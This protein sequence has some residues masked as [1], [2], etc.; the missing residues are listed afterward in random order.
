MTSDARS[1]VLAVTGVPPSGRR[2]GARAGRAGARRAGW[3][4]REQIEPLCEEDQE[5]EVREQLYARP[6]PAERTVRMVERSQPPAP[7]EV[8][9]DRPAA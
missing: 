9:A 5:A 2:A 8:F 3:F 4:S 6:A 1:N 7:L